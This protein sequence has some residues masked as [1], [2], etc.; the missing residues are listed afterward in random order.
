MSSSQALPAALL[1]SPLRG[2]SRS[3]GHRQGGP[4]SRQH[5]VA[6]RRQVR[7]GNQPATAANR[8]WLRPGHHTGFGT[9]MPKLGRHSGHQEDKMGRVFAEAWPRWPG[10]A[11]ALSQTP[12]PRRWRPLVQA[13][14]A[15]GRGRTAERAPRSRAP[16][17]PQPA[18]EGAG[19]AR[20]PGPLPRRRHP[21]PAPAGGHGIHPRNC[22]CQ[23]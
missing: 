9:P 21:A 16:Q 14:Q 20:G 22:S 7:H 3:D 19:G 15:S 12:S 17:C 13:H 23:Q 4:K 5:L 6:L 1:P 10:A 8:V 2:P 11:G 18:C